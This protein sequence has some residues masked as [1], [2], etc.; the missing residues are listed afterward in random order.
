MKGRFV[1][2]E[3]KKGII[4]TYEF[5]ISGKEEH[6]WFHLYLLGDLHV[7]HKSCNLTG[8]KDMVA[9]IA[10]RDP[11]ITA[12]ILTG[13]N[14]E[15]V[16]PG[17]KGSAFELSIPDPKDQV[18]TAA[19]LLLP[20]SERVVASYEGNHSFRS[21]IAASWSPDREVAKRLGS[22]KKHLG[23]SGYFTL[24][25]HDGRRVQRYRVWGEHGA[26]NA[27]TM[28]GKVRVLTSMADQHPDAD[29]YIMGHIH[30][31]MAIP[32]R[33]ERIRGQRSVI[34]K[35]M[36]ASNGS[37]LLDAEYSKRLGGVPGGQGVAKIQLS[38]RRRDIHCS[39]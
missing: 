6:D 28:S 30:T 24:C 4:P 36:F 39:I 34:E 25:L 33:V 18:D 35:V 37:Y 21:E 19:R 27:R 5:Q 3:L 8:I 20:I 22:E 29:V 16:I 10:S 11:K 2:S 1:L 38:T 32:N 12:V 7:G 17:S 9:Y 26:R 31:K 13:D 15:N 14:T 23:Y